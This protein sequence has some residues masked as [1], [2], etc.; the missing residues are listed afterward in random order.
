MDFI[1][2]LC[3]AT[4]LVYLVT[5]SSLSCRQM[6]SLRSMIGGGSGGN[7]IVGRNI[8]VVIESISCVGGVFALELPIVLYS[9]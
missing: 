1:A 4:W 7:N 5:S 8:V 2:A 9:K 6:Y 3:L